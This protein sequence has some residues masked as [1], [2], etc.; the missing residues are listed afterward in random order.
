MR[1]KKNTPFA[2]SKSAKRF[3]KNE[4]NRSENSNK[5]TTED[6]EANDKK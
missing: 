6:V 5:G 4:K 3:S 2:K 1:K